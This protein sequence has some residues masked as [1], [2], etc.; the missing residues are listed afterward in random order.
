[1]FLTILFIPLHVSTH[2]GHH[3]VVHLQK[4]YKPWIAIQLNTTVLVCGHIYIG[5]I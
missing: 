1:M 4:R 2:E 3:Q 5:Y